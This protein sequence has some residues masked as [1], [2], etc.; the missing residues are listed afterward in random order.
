MVNHSMLKAKPY[1]GEAVTYVQQKLDGHRVLCLKNKELVM[2]TRTGADLYPQL[3]EKAK[4]RKIWGWLER[5]QSFPN[6]SSI[7]AELLVPGQ[8]AS[9]VKT[10]IKEED[11]RLTLVAFAVPW[12][13]G[14]ELTCLEAAFEKCEKHGIEFAAFYYFEDSPKVLN[15]D[16]WEKQIAEGQEGWIA[17]KANYKG[18]YKIK[19][20]KTLDAFITGFKDGEGKYLGD[21]GALDC[22]IYKSDGTAVEICSCSGMTDEVR[23]ALTRN[24]LLRVVEVKYQLVGAKGRL[25]HP[26]F[27]HFRDDKQ[28]WEC[29]TAQ[30]NDLIR[31]WE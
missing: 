31:I 18:W 2:R 13:A 8:P 4:R 24:D 12:Y 17:K 21:V 27:L 6:G 7:D 30:D 10:A 5:L 26:N 1:N 11:P 22:S 15:V 29:T 3:A 16:Y 14:H 20:F 25:R 28:A 19:L 23:R 9:Y